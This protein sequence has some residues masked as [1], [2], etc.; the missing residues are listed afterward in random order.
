LT[1][2]GELWQANLDLVQECL[3]PPFVQGIADGTLER[4]KFAY[5]VGQDAFFLEAFARAYSVLAA[6]S[7]DGEVFRIFHNLA[8][9]VPEEMRL[10]EDFAATWEVDLRTVQPQPATRRYTDFLVATAW[11]SDV[12]I[13]TVAMLPCMRLYTFL[14]QQLASS[15]VPNHEYG[16]WIS[17]YS[18]PEFEK[19]AQQLETLAERYSS[20]T[21]Q[22]HST[23][24]YAMLCERDFFEAAWVVK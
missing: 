5:Y 23:Y 7:T 24:R 21:P 12:G 14:G 2:S 4:K 17:T 20:T 19:L 1:V 11:S 6:K 15:G 10:H 13:T 18:D 16:N 8:A 3:K 22:V 9:G